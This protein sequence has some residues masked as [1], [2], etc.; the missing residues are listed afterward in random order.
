MTLDRTP[1]VRR[2]TRFPF[3]QSG[4]ASFYVFQLIAAQPE[5]NSLARPAPGLCA[6]TSRARAAR[7]ASQGAR[8]NAMCPRRPAVVPESRRS[9]PEPYVRILATRAKLGDSDQEKLFFTTEK[10]FLIRFASELRKRLLTREELEW[11]FLGIFSR[12]L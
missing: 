8:R 7:R 1:P 9:P 11:H 3:S 12:S 5:R 10:V 2:V 6:S 4:K